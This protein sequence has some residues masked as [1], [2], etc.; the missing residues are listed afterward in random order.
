MDLPFE[1]RGGR[2]WVEATLRGVRK[3]GIFDTGADGTAID[4]ELSEGLGLKRGHTQAATTV[5]ADIGVVKTDPVE[6]GL[7]RTSLTADEANILP[8]STHIQG[9]DFILGFDALKKVPFTIDYSKGFLRF[10]SVPEGVRM[11]FALDKDIRPTTELKVAGASIT[12]MLDTGAAGGIS[13]RV[14]WVKKNLAKLRLEEP[15]KRVILGSEYESR[16]FI[17]EEVLLGGATL[18]KVE[19]EAVAAEEGAFGDQDESLVE[20]GNTVLKLFEQVG[21]DGERRMTTSVHR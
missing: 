11:P 19:A 3:S 13:F 17:L 18:T 16:K 2:I 21:I 10:G 6:F 14:S 12:A 15:Q 4:Q 7:G 9:L 20:V 5:S 1:L 8:L